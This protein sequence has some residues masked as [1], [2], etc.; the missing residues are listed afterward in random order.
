LLTHAYFSDSLSGLYLA[1]LMSNP[2]AKV[3][4]KKN[5]HWQIRKF[6]VMLGLVS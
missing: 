5:L 4:T 6:S 2:A 3:T 1:A